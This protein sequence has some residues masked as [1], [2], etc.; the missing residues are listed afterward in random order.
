MI[1]E[2]DSLASGD[3]LLT[4]EVAG[5][6]YALPIAEVLEVSDR[7]R[8]TCIP[9]LPLRCGGVMNWHGDALPVIWPQLLLQGVEAEDEEAPEDSALRALEGADCHVLV[10]TDR[11]DEQARL[12]LPIDRVHGLVNGPPRKASAGALVVE[13]RP[14]DG[15][16]VSV[17]DPRQLV[18]RAEEVIRRAAA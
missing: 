16:V 4:F 9:T 10:V 2:S 3:R 14:I 12:G 13:R 18:A 11:P 7:A 17:L 5:V 8:L 15:R 1:E 6:V